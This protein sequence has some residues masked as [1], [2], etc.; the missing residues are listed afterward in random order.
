MRSIAR[1]VVCGAAALAL[2]LGATATGPREPSSRAA[3]PAP[4][5]EPDGLLVLA[6]LSPERAMVG[7]P[8][9][10]RTV[11]R[12]LPGGTLCHG[13]VLAFG[14]R[15]LIFGVRRSRVVPRSLALRG[16]G[17]ARSLGQADTVIDSS[18][19]GRLWL[20]RWTRQ[21][22]R[23]ARLALREIDAAGHVFARTRWLLPRWATENAV[24]DDG[25]LLITR[26]RG[27]VLRR[28][29]GSRLRFAGGSP[30]AAGGDR[31]AWHDRISSGVRLW[32]RDGGERA[33]DPPAGLRL[34]DTGGAAFSPDGRRLALTVT[35]H[36]G[37]RVAVI[38]LAAGLWRVAPGA[39]VAGYKA[40]AWSPS[41]RWLYFTGPHHRL[42][43]SR[44][45][46]DRAR[47]LPIR[48]GGTVMSI[49]S[50]PGSAAR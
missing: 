27:V 2:G 43:A 6:V 41:G 36:E 24:M 4:A 25:S 47:R 20:G 30:L 10:G 3:R 15:V 34:D 18:A 32:T 28:P 21:G 49:A 22:D 19:P 31:F 48:T 8:R 42:L 16:D 12:Q 5:R 17:P 26:G 50:T 7:D 14:D 29:G 45:G 11:A 33:F 38:D 23:T 1:V 44:G 35:A 9:T 39:S 46:I 40:I 13:P 37:S